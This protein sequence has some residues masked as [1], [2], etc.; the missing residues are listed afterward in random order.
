M[1]QELREVIALRARL[2]GLIDSFET[3]QPALASNVHTKT[4]LAIEIAVWR[5]P[6]CF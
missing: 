2:T 1:L 4:H 6:T 3:E 5:V